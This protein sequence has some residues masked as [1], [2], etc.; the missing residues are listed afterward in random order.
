M[1][2]D[3]QSVPP[4]PV[5]NL[6]L[7][8]SG[9]LFVDGAP[10]EVA[11]GQSATTV[12]V[13]AVAEYV[14]AHDLNAVRVRAATPEG[15]FQMIV[16]ADGE[17]ID[18]TPPPERAAPRR[19]PL[20]LAAVGTSVLAVLSLTAVGVALA[21][22][23]EP[24]PPA[25]T[26]PSTPAPLPGAGANLPVL[27]PPGFAQKATW[28]LPVAARSTPILLADGRV[29][30]TDP[31]GRLRVVDGATAATT[32]TG[33]K[34]RADV[35]PAEVQGR[36]VLA[37]SSGEE[38]SLW[39]LD[40]GA[41][42]W[43]GS[44][45]TLDLT[46]RGKVTYLGS[47]PLVTLENQTVALFDGDGLTRR[48]I[49][50][51]ARPILATGEGVVAV[52]PDTWWLITADDEPQEHE[53]PRPAGASGKPLVVSAAT[54][55]QLFVTWSTGDDSAVAALIDLTDGTIRASSDIAAGAIRADAEPLHDPTGDSM[56]LGTVLVDY[57]D[58]PHVAQLEDITPTAVHGRTVYGSSDR[59]AAIASSTGTVRVY[60]ES[61]APALPF[62]V[63]DDFAYFVAEKV[64]Q[65]LL[66]AL[67]RTTERTNP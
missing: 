52:G 29:V 11:D 53:L 51:G 26:G 8:T 33:S 41:D 55:S 30:L 12:G 2:L 34:A 65:T 36:P 57:S 39:P 37:A 14:R 44:P 58:T 64:D 60:G 47:V 5:V 62:A 67:P 46:A 48:D 24:A 25:A 43:D 16:T 6:R 19:R 61:T 1:T 56:T 66:Y 28:A 3:P 45:V 50:V 27:A 38:L 9:E 40:L 17:A 63:T 22:G 10:V 59:R 23:D 13:Q 15:T 42:E 32:W 21:G 4:F 20:L 31:D 49:P 35:H 7:E 54:D 18:T